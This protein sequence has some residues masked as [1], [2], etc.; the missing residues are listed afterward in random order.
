MFYWKFKKISKTALIKV[1][2]KDQRYYILK[3][4][5]I[6]I[7]FTGAQAIPVLLC[8][9]YAWSGYN[10][11]SEVWVLKMLKMQREVRNFCLLL[12]YL[13]RF[14]VCFLFFYVACRCFI[15]PIQTA[16]QGGVSIVPLPGVIIQSLNKFFT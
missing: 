16:F 1:L 9:K 3:G 2:E 13:R 14:L 8:S 10:L 7:I 6:Q 12:G 5:L 4:N 15:L 11:T